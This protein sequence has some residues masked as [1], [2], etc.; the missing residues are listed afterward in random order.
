MQRIAPPSLL[1]IPAP[2]A[3]AVSAPLTLD[4]EILVR[5]QKFELQR[6]WGEAL[7]VY[8]DANRSN[9]GAPGLGE[10]IDLARIHYDLGR[11]YADASFRHSLSQLDENR[12]LDLYT[13]VLNKILRITSPIPIGSTW[14]S[15]ARWIS[16]S[17]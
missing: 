10:R 15:M 17:P 2:P 1:P 8:E 5:G 4:P 13:E 6:R 12:A 3:P 7:S 9:P 16:K 11:R 14:S